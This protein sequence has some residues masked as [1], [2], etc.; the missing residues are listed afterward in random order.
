MLAAIAYFPRI[1]EGA[2]ARG[3]HFPVDVE[4]RRAC[5]LRWD[6]AVREQPGGATFA[7]GIGRKK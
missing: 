6:R 3:V 1:P 4:L 5:S 7:C 2:L